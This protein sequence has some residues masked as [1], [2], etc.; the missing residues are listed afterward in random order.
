MSS[1]IRVCLNFDVPFGWAEQ[2][3]HEIM[4]VINQVIQDNQDLQENACLVGL[5]STVHILSRMW[6]F[7]ISV[8]MY[9]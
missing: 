6:L 7:V 1:L 2:V 8:T 9:N 4:R 3:L 5:V